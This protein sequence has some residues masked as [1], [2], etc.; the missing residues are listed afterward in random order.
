MHLVFI[1]PTAL[2]LPE[3]HQQKKSFK[4]ERTNQYRLFWGDVL[5]IIDVCVICSIVSECVHLLLAHGAPVKVK[6]AQ[7]WSPLAEAISYGDRQTSKYWVHI[8]SL[9]IR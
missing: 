2:W 9:M 6:N 5:Y 3:K 4:N 7:G 1:I 8:D